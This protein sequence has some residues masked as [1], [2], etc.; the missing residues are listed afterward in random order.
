M[1]SMPGEVLDFVGNRLAAFQLLGD[2]FLQPV[3]RN[4]PQRA[5]LGQLRIQATP[6]P[7]RQSVGPARHCDRRSAGCATPLGHRRSTPAFWK[8]PPENFATAATAATVDL[9]LHCRRGKQRQTSPPPDED[10]SCCQTTPVHHVHLNLIYET[11]KRA[12]LQ[13]PKHAVGSHDY[14]RCRRICN[15]DHA[16]FV[17]SSDRVRLGLRQASAA[18]RGDATDIA[19]LPGTT[20]TAAIRSTVAQ[21]V[22]FHGRAAAES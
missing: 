20:T 19:A 21:A 12:S 6:S 3:E 16:T 4:L 8:L 14:G 2:R 9:R 22:R 11:H 13:I 7:L 5:A 1:R 15:I 17:S 18:D 10:E